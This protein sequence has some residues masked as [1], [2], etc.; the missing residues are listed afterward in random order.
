[1][2]T[3]GNLDGEDMN[4]VKTKIRMP[5]I[6]QKVLGRGFLHTVPVIKEGKQMGNQAVT[7][8]REQVQGT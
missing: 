6:R 4:Q 1:M 7:V 5:S 2:V 3:D 8:L